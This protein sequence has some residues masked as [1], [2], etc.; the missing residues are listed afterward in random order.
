MVSYCKLDVGIATAGGI[1]VDEQDRVY[2]ASNRPDLFPP[3][4][5][6]GGVFRYS[7]PFPTLNTPAGGCGLVDGTGAPLATTVNKQIFILADAFATTPSAVA[8]SLTGT[9]YVSSVF[10]GSIAEYDANG[11]FVRSVL[12]PPAGEVLPFS[13]G[14]PYG[15]AVDSAGTI[16]YADLGVGVGPPPGPEDNAGSEFRIRFQDGQPM[17]PELRDDGLD[18]PDG[19]GILEI[20]LG[21]T[22]TTVPGTSTT[23]TTTLPGALNLTQ[24]SLRVSS[25]VPNGGIL[26]KGDFIT[27]PAFS[28]PPGFTVR[29]RDSLA[30]DRTHTFSNCRSRANGG[31]RCS[32]PTMSGRVQ[33]SFTR[34]RTS[35]VYRFR[36]SFTRE[37]VTGPF[38]GPVTMT[39][40]HN[41]G[42]TRTDTISDCRQ[43]GRGLSCREG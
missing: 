21:S 1:Y 18:Y 20:P 13:T 17:A 35:G 12:S 11:L 34:F 5:N 15:I 30:L 9:F 16:Y 26:V 32:D 42:A 27:P 38:S 36:V 24:V 8:R 6:P 40:L 37:N 29:V 39:L 19:M 2:V 43:T 23:T 28:F 22:T 7:P 14:T 41:A 25:G 10:T 4:T 31:V 33:A 3:T